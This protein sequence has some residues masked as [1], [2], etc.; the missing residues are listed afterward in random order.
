MHGQA[1]RHKSWGERT[2]WWTERWE[3]AGCLCP[4]PQLAPGRG[5][6]PPVR[7]RIRAGLPRA[8]AAV[9]LGFSVCLVRLAPPQP[10][11]GEWQGP[12]LMEKGGGRGRA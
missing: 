12:T 1:P 8:F 5:L 3:P 7:V 6:R 2:G 11:A 4:C 10:Q 9:V